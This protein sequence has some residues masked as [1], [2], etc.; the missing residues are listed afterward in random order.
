MMQPSLETN[1]RWISLT[2]T[3]QP[4]RRALSNLTNPVVAVATYAD[5]APSEILM[6][7]YAITW[8][9]YVAAPGS[10]FAIA[11]SAYVLLRQVPEPAL[12][13]VAIAIGG[14][15]F[16]AT[17]WGSVCDRR[18]AARVI[19]S[20]YLMLFGVFCVSGWGLA[21]AFYAEYALVCCWLVW[22]LSAQPCD[23]RTKRGGKYGE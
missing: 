12:G 15:Q 13:L 20:W 19:C 1:F 8:G 9:L 17:C 7:L 10:A 22:R 18:R 14:T 23:C 11:P 2:T 21:V 3:F 16:W 4:L 5:T 6:S